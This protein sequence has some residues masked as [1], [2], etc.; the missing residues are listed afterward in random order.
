MRHLRAGVALLWVARLRVVFSP[1]SVERAVEAEQRRVSEE[2]R[3]TLEALSPFPGGI[4]RDS[5]PRPVNGRLVLYRPE[6]WPPPLVGYGRSPVG[7][8]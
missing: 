2:A 8:G 1:R 5:L 7:R 3:A 4:L 6:G